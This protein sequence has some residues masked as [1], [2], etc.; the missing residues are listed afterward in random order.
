MAS[1]SAQVV[2]SGTVGPLPMVAGESPGT[3]LT[4]S[5]TTRAG[6][7]I[8][9]RR[10][11]LIADRCLRTQFISSIAAPLFS[12]A[13]LKARFS[14]SVTPSAGKA[15]S[16]DAPPDIRQMTRSSAVK[17]CASA[18]I[19]SAARRPAASGT[20]CAASTTSMRATRR[21]CSAAKAGG[22]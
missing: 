12:K 16:E 2:G 3:S 14:S 11:P 19:R 8:A 22:T 18:A 1:A 13:R 9:A 15:S 21:A 10:P 7:L 20:G 4:S 17:P 6:A 5:V